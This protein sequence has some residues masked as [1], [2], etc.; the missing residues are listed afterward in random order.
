MLN[1]L[2]ADEGEEE[3]LGLRFKRYL[4]NVTE[5]EGRPPLLIMVHGRAGDFNVMWVFSKVVE[6][7]GV[8]RPVTL[9]PQAVAADPVGGFSWWP[10]Y[11][12]P[13]AGQSEA[14]K[15]E[16]LHEVE[17]GVRSVESFIEAAE[18]HYNT[19]PQRRF[20]FGF[21]QGGALAATLS[22]LRPDLFRG[23]AILAGF[24]PY[25]VREDPGLKHPSVDSGEATLPEYFVAHGTEDPI[26]PFTR[27]LDT[28]DWLEGKGARVTFHED[29]TK[30]KIGT[31]G[32]KA[33]AEWYRRVSNTSK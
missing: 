24:I 11:P 15:A 22:L 7:E 27:A 25:A 28:R 29:A 16:R 33:L 12:T 14:V 3:E 8:V 4:P 32:I 17:V 5:V 6:Q 21:S 19:D 26:L 2:E 18:R 30:H 31:A 20:I 9:A 10:V 13:A 1:A 23:V